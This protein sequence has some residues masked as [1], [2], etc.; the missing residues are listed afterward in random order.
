MTRM[1]KS[2]RRKCPIGDLLIVCV[3]AVAVREGGGQRVEE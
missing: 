3:P 2:F 1:Q